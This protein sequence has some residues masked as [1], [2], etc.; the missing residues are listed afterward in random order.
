MAELILRLRVDPATGKRELVIDYTSD[1]DALPNAHEAA[2][3]QLAGRLI[4]GGLASGKVEIRRPAEVAVD[5]PAPA[6][7]L[8]EAA[9]VAHPTSRR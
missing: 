8:A 1:G 7:D 4:A 5:A 2:H 9:P 3:R 6:I